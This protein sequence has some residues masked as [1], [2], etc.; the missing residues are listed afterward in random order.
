MERRLIKEYEA[1]IDEVLDGLKADNLDLAVRLAAVPELISGYGHI[2]DQHL[3][4]ANALRDGLL[5]DWRH[6][7]QG[8]GNALGEA[9]E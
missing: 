1:M 6:P 4:S 2:K 7:D 5:A 3:A 9:A 8:P